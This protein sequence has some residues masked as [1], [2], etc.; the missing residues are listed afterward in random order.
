MWLENLKKKTLF[1]W[2]QLSFPLAQSFAE[3]NNT[4]K[5][6]S[7]DQNVRPVTGQ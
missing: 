4:R 7:G 1:S 5:G 2:F 6:C 3:Q